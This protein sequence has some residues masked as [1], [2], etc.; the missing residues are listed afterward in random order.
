MN[1]IRYKYNC[2]STDFGSPLQPCVS[3]GGRRAAGKDGERGPGARTLGARPIRAV[4][5]GEGE[6]GPEMGGDG[7]WVL[8]TRD[9]D[10]LI[11]YVM[12]ESY[13]GFFSHLWA[14]F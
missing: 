8:A 5:V 14:F 2:K 13:M 7:G 4:H 1:T 3:P 10:I 12:H 6:P 9:G 11:Y